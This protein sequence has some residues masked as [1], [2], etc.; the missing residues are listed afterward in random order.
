MVSPLQVIFCIY[1]SS[2][3]KNENI[4]GAMALA[5][6]WLLLMQCFTVIVICLLLQQTV[7]IGCLLQLLELQIYQH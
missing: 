2:H 3:I 5:L 6:I 7:N 1:Y 4:L